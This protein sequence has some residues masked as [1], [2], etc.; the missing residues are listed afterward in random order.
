MTLLL[1]VLLPLLGALLPPWFVRWG[2]TQS[3]VAAG[4]AAGA[5]FVLMLSLLPRV[6]AGETP[7]FSVPWMPSIGLD[8]AFRMDG[9]G[10]LFSILIL[11]IGLLVIL[12][13]RHYLSREDPMG[14]FYAF[15]L[16]FM[17]SMLGVVLADNLLLLVVFW[18]LTS[19]SSFL[20]IGFWTHKPEARQGARMALV[21]TGMGGLFLLLGFIL[22]AD[23][24][25]TTTIS[26]INLRGAAIQ[27]SAGYA[28]ML[29]LILLGAF[30]KSAQFPFQFWLPHA[31]AAPTPVSAFLHSAT[32]VKAGV[33][34]LARFFPALAGTELWFLLV[35][36]VGVT[37]MVIAAYIALTK[38]DLKALLAYSTISHL[39]IITACFGI[40]T[41]AAAIVG[42]FHIL[43]HAAFKASLF[44]NAGIVDHE[45]GTRD[46][47][48]LG[49]LRKT[50]PVTAALALLASAAMAGLPP[51]NGF[52]SK[53]MFFYETTHL[54]HSF[55]PAW[56]LPAIVTLGGLF[57]V[58]YSI[59]YAVDPFFGPE[60]P[61]LPKTPHEPPRPMRLPVELLVALCVLI[62]L[63]PETIAGGLVHA[64]A[65]ATVGSELPGDHGLAL[66][67]GVNTALFMSMIAIAGGVVAWRFRHGIIAL[68]AGPLPFPNGKRI[69]ERII[70]G[71]VRWSE[72]LTRLL[73][74][75]AH[76]VG[77]IQRYLLIFVAVAVAAVGGPLLFAEW[78]AGTMA[79]TPM[80]P[81]SAVFGIFLLVG[82]IGTVVFHHDRIRALLAISVVGLVISLAFVQLSAPDLALTQIS[83]EV[84][85]IV[86]LLL[87]LHIL[88]ER[89]P[90]GD[91]S[92]LVLGRD[93]IVAVAAGAAMATV[94][95]VL[96]TTDVASI[97]DFFVEQSKPG[98]GGYNVVNVILVDFRGY[99][100]FGEITVLGI[101]ALG[102]YALIDGMGVSSRWRVGTPR[103]ELRY[104]LLLTTI[105]RLTLPLALLVSVYIFL[106]G[107]NEPGGGFIA[108]LVTAVALIIQ[109]I[110]SGI[111]WTQE[112]LDV[113][114]HKVIGVGITAAGMAGVG[115]FIWGAPFLTGW[116]DYFHFPVIGELELASAL[117]FDL[118][119]Y[120]TVVSVVIL[121]LVNMGKIRNATAVDVPDDRD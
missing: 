65:L 71:G 29:L 93:A 30:T 46:L 113:D 44:M 115:A 80:D 25:G 88:P 22:L 109:Y 96:M 70:F 21:I 119:V 76:Q 69:F 41:P 58:A 3:A 4:G 32:M 83:V 121:M 61:N 19:L 47:R 13:A 43:N 110:A 92:S 6:M 94:S 100:T 67:H 90:K 116:F 18:E 89:C 45:A 74:A 79:R 8:L 99:D 111:G 72:A 108:G 98:G 15:L 54:Y 27:A 7:S 63:F 23:A 107:H 39:G 78:S 51:F 53:E 85:T 62:G 97:S 95:W 57:S 60:S 24:A 1:I 73:G 75:G 105:S 33:F 34:L 12:Y 91:D 2:R 112:R 103:D 20:L 77:S 40:G 48:M 68:H 101:A 37:T 36:G 10:L 117:L 55:G 84:V 35:T 31:M 52:I 87:A 14:R 5:S 81:I 82:T 118:G 49:G 64:A 120:L 56:L 114:L 26:E 102:I 86:L 17:A 106:R 59:R 16:F 66:W 28:P 104:P 11:G 50:M 9:L 38:H 42:V